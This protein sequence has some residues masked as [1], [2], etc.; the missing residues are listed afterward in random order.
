MVSLRYLLSLGCVSASD[1]LP[2]TFTC[3]SRRGCYGSSPLSFESAFQERRAVSQAKKTPV[4]EL[5]YRDMSRSQK[6][7]FIGK[8]FI[9]FVSGGFIYPTI[10]I[11]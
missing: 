9:F 8:A 11:D 7:A 5:A 3:S 4:P 6:I 10:W 1:T 2:N